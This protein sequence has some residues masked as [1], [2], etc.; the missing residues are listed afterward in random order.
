MRRDDWDGR[1]GT[2]Q[3]G[4]YQGYAVTVQRDA[5][6]TGWHIWLIPTIDR[7]LPFDIWADDL[8]QLEEWFQTDLADTR[9]N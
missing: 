4:R 3:S 6:R 8:E 9:W 7:G 2:V 5:S 1:S